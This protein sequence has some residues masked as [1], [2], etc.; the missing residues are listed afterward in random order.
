MVAP[1]VVRSSP[2]VLNTWLSHFHLHFGRT[3]TVTAQP[4]PFSSQALHA[5]PIVRRQ[6]SERPS[7][8][9][10]RGLDRGQSLPRPDGSLAIRH[11]IFHRTIVPA[12]ANCRVPLRGAEQT[13]RGFGRPL[14]A[15]V[16]APNPAR[17]GAAVD[18]SARRQQRV[19]PSEA[20]AS[21]PAAAKRLPQLAWRTPP[22]VAADTR[23]EAASAGVSD[24]LMASKRVVAKRLPALAWRTPL[25]VAADTRG[26]AASA[27]GGGS[28]MASKRVVAKRPPELVWRAPAK[29][30]GPLH[31]MAATE[32][33]GP[34]MTA[35]RATSFR[36]GG[37]AE[38]SQ[39]AA[40]A[41]PMPIDPSLM[42]RLAEDV[43]RRVE[44]RNRIDRERRGI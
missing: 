29:A 15:H 4:R 40:I 27:G 17:G 35:I 33:N 7:T 44:R 21:K 3:E 1:R 10:Y 14:S 36:T 19:E 37:S 11:S 2:T 31:E 24:S 38:A 41:R 22:K 26:E 12:P 28:P 23:D 20:A 18:T 42:D 5:M 32:A 25:K 8:R 43:I 39:A 30:A 16:V 13:L 9:G 6:P 34:A